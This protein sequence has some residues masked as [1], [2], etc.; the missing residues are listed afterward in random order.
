MSDLP[1]IKKN[2][3][4]E[5]KL[6]LY[7]KK[8]E[9][10]KRAP[11]LTV[12]VLT[13]NPRFNVY[14][15]DPQNTIIRAKLDA[16]SFMAIAEYLY[17][18]AESEPGT[19]RTWINMTGAPSKMIEDTRVTVGKNGKGV[20]FISA[21]KKDGERIV[22]PFL[23]SMYHK[24]SD[25]EGEVPP[26]RLS[27]MYARAWAKLLIELVPNLLDSQFVEIPPYQG[28]GGK[29]G[30]G[31]R[32]GNNRGNYGGGNGNNSGGGQSSNDGGGSA[33]NFDDFGD[34]LPM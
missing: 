6:A 5:R 4:D 25:E 33:T 3:F 14:T 28:D 1:P 16:P 10:M 20:V 7:G 22:F 26:D 19:T 2:A 32:G 30:Y 9:E 23:P 8:T 31:N 24:V 34:D 13:N 29:G 12:Q 21:Y 27:V 15:N 11:K 18:V 17:E